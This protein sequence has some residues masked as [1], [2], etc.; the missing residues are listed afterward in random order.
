MLVLSRKVNEEIQIGDDIRIVVT[1]IRGGRVRIGIVA[2]R[3]VPVFRKEV[4][5][6]REGEPRNV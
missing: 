3:D 2:P 4:R 5:E 1:D 6:T